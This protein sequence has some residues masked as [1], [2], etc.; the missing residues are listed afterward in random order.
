M[1]ERIQNTESRSQNNYPTKK[2]ITGI[3]VLKEK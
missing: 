1:N 2:K 3:S